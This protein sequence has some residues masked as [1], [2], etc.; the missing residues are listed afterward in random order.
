[1]KKVGV[2]AVLISGRTLQQ[3]RT[4]ELGKL[5]EDYLSSVAVCEM[6]ANTMEVLGIHEGDAV[7]L[8]TLLGDVVVRSKL[9]QNA[10]PGVVFM[11]WGPHA[12]TIL[13]SETHG[14]G[15][16]SYK[17]VPVILFPAP[18]TS[19]RTIDDLLHLSEGGI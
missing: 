17:G 10:R 18:D 1:M 5:S 13:G 12:N 3:G 7:R 15:M 4:S 8:E 6:D 16:P 2:K 9:D 11:P 14:C 19:V